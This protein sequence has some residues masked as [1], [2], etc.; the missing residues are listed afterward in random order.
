M[1]AHLNKSQV[2]TQ[3]ETKKAR[4]LGSCYNSHSDTKF[5]QRNPLAN[6][7][8]SKKIQFDDPIPDTSNFD[9]NPNTDQFHTGA[10]QVPTKQGAE[11]S[12]SEHL[13]RE[14]KKK[15]RTPPRP[16]HSC[17]SINK[18]TLRAP[19]NATVAETNQKKDRRVDRTHANS[20]PLVRWIRSRGRNKQRLRRTAR[21][22][23]P[24]CGAIA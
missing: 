8:L 17:K 15:V 5:L 11:N 21:C 9:L 2:L 12:S 16:W 13:T 22:R 19:R 23:S 20:A 1:H 24:S 4:S 6:Q 3:P 14:Q 18:S 10:S 7:K